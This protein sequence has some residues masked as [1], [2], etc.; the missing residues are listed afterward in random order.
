MTEEQK[1]EEEHINLA[2]H[3]CVVYV[4]YVQTVQQLI[5][6][7]SATNEPEEE[8][9]KVMVVKGASGSGKSALVAHWWLSVRLI[10]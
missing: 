10:L 3:K 6:F 1:Q 2:R 5:N 9:G 8:K 4:P 7:V